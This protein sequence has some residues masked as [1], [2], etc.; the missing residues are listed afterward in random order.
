MDVFSLTDCFFGYFYFILSLNDL[1]DCYRENIFAQE[2]LP[3]NPNTILH[4]FSYHIIIILTD[5]DIC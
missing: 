2:I 3:E 5:R 4:E 1:F